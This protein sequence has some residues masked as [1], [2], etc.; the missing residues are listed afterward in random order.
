PP[1]SDHPEHHR[2]LPGGPRTALHGNLRGGVPAL[3]FSDH[4]ADSVCLAVNPRT[5][6]FAPPTHLHH[7]AQHLFPGKTMK[8]ISLQIP[9]RSP[10]AAIRV[11]GAQHPSDFQY[12]ASQ[13]MPYLTTNSGN[14]HVRCMLGDGGEGHIPMPPEELTEILAPLGSPGGWE[15]LGRSR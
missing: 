8:E 12:V 5:A 11:V 3:Y 15:D 13:M 4:Y 10:P 2:A 7:N 6:L 14:E 9:T 1:P